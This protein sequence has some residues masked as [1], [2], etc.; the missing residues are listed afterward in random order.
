MMDPQEITAVD[1]NGVRWTWKS[2]PYDD[3]DGFERSFQWAENEAGETK[4]LAFS[5]FR[6]YG[7]KHFR[8]LVEHGFPTRPGPVIANWYP[9]ELEA[10]EAAK[11]AA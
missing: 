9:E 1:P 7:E 3:S 11:V 6:S 5:D 10:L 8:I 2:E 4:T